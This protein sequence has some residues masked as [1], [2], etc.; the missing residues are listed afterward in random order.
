MRSFTYEPAASNKGRSAL[1][2]GAITYPSP[3][4]HS[5]HPTVQ[6]VLGEG[7]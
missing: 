5:D 6:K 1:P 3:W 4:E 2:D 7:P